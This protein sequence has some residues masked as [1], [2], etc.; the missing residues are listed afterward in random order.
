MEESLKPLYLV[1]V[2]PGANNNKYYRMIPNGDYF[3]VQY[4]R[5]GVTS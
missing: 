3:T 5:I 4:G 1:K 2:E